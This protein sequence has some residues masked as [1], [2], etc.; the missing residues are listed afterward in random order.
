LRY[1]SLFSGL[2]AAHL[3]WAPLGWTCVAVA[4]V[5]PAACAVLAQRLPD[6]PNLGD[7]TAVTDADIAAL[8]PIDVVIGGSPCQDLSVAG[9]R[10]GLDGAKS[11][12]FF[13]Q[14]RL[15][16]AARS[17]CHAR[18]L[19]WENV[20]GAFTSNR[21]AD[22]AR[23]VGAI[24]G[25]ELA[26]PETGWGT[27]G[28]A[29]GCHGLAEWCVLDAQWF[30]LAQR[31]RR[32]FVVLDTGDWAAREPVLLEPDRLRGDCPPCRAAG[33]DLAACA[34]AGAASSGGGRI[35]HD[36]STAGGLITAAMATGQGGAEI[37]DGHM[38]PTLTC[39]REPPLIAHTLRA[40]HD[41]SEDGTGRGV[42]L[43]PLPFDTTQLTSPASRSTPRI[44]DPCHTLAAGANPP[45]IAFGWQDSDPMR[46]M[47]P[48]TAPALRVCGQVAVHT[49]AHA[50]N[51]QAGVT[52]QDGADSCV[53][54]GR[55]IR[56]L[57][58]RE[59]ERL[60][61]VPDDWTLVPRRKGLMADG[62][63]YR[64]LGNSFA[65]PVIGWIGQRIAAA[66]RASA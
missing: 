1:L 29:V 54:V 44:G 11:G 18:W 26:V 10:A 49:V 14:L 42:P 35:G 21:R 34:A 8:G 55:T 25:C 63:R 59:C 3:A 12:L 52:G 33:S 23:V 60:Q 19:V 66:H 7:V 45:A 5:E 58:P 61:G 41:A 38:A 39:D 43:V 15:F 16:H 17:L 62:P 30:G 20:P 48:R 51:H 28:V 13:E 22:F 24:S 57:T 65:V 53:F 32:V 36:P 40:S 46:T 47:R 6:V 64:L 9:H 56:R 4:E 37:T 31:R 27:E 50:L 2:E